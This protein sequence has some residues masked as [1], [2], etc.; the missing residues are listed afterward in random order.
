M[1][2]NEE[3]LLTCRDNFILNFQNPLLWS[4]FDSYD[5]IEWSLVYQCVISILFKRGMF[6]LFAKG[7]YY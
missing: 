2:C 1:N 6:L 7:L 4:N 5:K 3:N